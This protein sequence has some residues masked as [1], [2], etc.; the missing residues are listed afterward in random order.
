MV[1]HLLGG[2]VVEDL[3]NLEEGAEQNLVKK[4]NTHTCIHSDKKP[5]QCLGLENKGWIS[6]LIVLNQK[7]NVMYGMY[8]YSWLTITV[9][10]LLLWDDRP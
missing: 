7:T 4:K 2:E 6:K 3:A 1:R 8:R 9:S 10:I 5:Q